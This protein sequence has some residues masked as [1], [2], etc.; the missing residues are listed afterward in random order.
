M[1]EDSICIGFRLPCGEW[2]GYFNTNRVEKK[3]GNAYHY[4]CRMG[5]EIEN[6]T[7]AD[8]WGISE[9]YFNEQ[10]KEGN[11]VILKTFKDLELY[12]ISIG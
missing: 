3:Y 5:V 9:E 7:F 8:F 10:M 1:I 11:L 12:N 4:F 6:A 2:K